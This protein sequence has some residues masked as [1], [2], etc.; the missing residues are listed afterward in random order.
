MFLNIIFGIKNVTARWLPVGVVSCIPGLTLG[1][2]PQ[3]GPTPH[4]TP[5]NFGRQKC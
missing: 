1:L 5:Q 2:T 4:T 3:T